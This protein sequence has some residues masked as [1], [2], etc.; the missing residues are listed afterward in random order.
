MVNVYDIQNA[1]QAPITGNL[2]NITLLI[3]FFVMDGQLRL[4]DILYST[5]KAMPIG[6][7]MFSPGIGLV[8]LDAF[9]RM[10]FLG[11][12]VAIPVIASGLMIEICFGALMRA[13]PQIHMMVI[14]VPLKLLIGFIIL[15]AIIPIYVSFAPTVF[16]DMFLWMDKMFESLAG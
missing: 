3:V 2:L 8:A 12:M 15:S 9:V 14:G 13:V 5:I 11:V 6:V 4:I 1:T 10:F 7:P 16:D